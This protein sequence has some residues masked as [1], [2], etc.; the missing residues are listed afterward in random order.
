[1]DEK[2]FEQ[3]LKNNRIPTLVLDQKW[4]RLFA[5]SGKPDNVKTLE[6]EE[7]EILVRQ[8]QLNQEVKELKK[9]KNDLMKGIVDNME[10]ADAKKATAESEKKLADNKRLLDDTNA[11]IEADED[12]LMDIPRLLKDKNDELM[13]ATMTYCY[14][15]LRTNASEAKEITEW[16]TNVRIELKKNIIKKQNREINNKE[17]YSYLHDLFGKDV[18]Q[19]FDVKYEEELPIQSTHHEES[20]SV[21]QKEEKE[22]NKDR[23]TNF[24]VK[25]DE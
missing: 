7:K 16:I 14:A 4:H 17:I 18:M 15:R 12:E 2:Q 10:G 6:V 22:A 24:N 5:I 21:R 9:I 25:K 20:A 23:S 11:K 1:M 8:G 19:M 13:L 3:A